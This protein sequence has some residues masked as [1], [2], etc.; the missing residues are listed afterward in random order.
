MNI[1]ETI[2]QTNNQTNNQTNQQINKQTNKQTKF[3]TPVLNNYL[4]M[5][6]MI[7]TPFVDN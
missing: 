3:G 2:K 6:M 5:M 4:I 1:L 7:D